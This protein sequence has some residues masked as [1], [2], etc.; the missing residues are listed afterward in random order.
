MINY[1]LV[2][3]GGGSAGLSAAISAYDNGIKSIVV[4]EKEK[5]PAEAGRHKVDLSDTEYAFY[6]QFKELSEDDKETL[7]DMVRV[8]RQRR[9]RE[10]IK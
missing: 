5:A 10:V 3:I 7:M 2:I 6:G 9:N 4:L 1:D 8:M